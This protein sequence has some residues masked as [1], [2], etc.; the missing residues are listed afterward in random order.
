MK[1]ITFFGG[2]RPAGLAVAT[3]VIAL[4]IADPAS[5]SDAGSAPA[6]D[7]AAFASLATAFLEAPSDPARAHAL[8]LA[9]RSA[10]QLDSAIALF[11]AAL[12][13]EPGALPA[14]LEL[15]LAHVDQ[16]AAPDL[17]QKQRFVLAGQ[18]IG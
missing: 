17:D 10:G 18:A 14:R 9:A 12:T 4:G 2:R 5:P 13:R 16:L 6:A 7:P 3:A 8:R 11:Q 1:R 15:G